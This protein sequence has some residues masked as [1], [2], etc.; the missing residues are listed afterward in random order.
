M[1]RDIGWKSNE[2]ILTCEHRCLLL[3]S[4]TSTGMLFR[5]I[6]P[7]FLAILSCLVWMDENI[8]SIAEVVWACV[9]HCYSRK[10]EHEHWKITIT[11]WHAKT[12]HSQK[13]E[14]CGFIFI[15]FRY[16]KMCPLSFTIV[17]YISIKRTLKCT[18]GQINPQTY[19]QL[20]MA[21]M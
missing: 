10:H 11:S 18:V 8:I 6:V 9:V 14:T 3:E 15:C 19:P 13:N 4:P 17:Y 7:W 20:T 2:F 1:A 12:P 5:G 21:D 16:K